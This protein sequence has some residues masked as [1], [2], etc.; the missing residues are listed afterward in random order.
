MTDPL[1]SGTAR[2][3]VARMTAA[4]A[5]HA[6]RLERRYR[7]VL[8]AQGF[9]AARMRAFLAITPAAASRL[10]ALSQFV[11]QVEYNGRRLA[12]L[13][14]DPFAAKEALKTFGALLE[15]ALPGQ[16]EPAREQ[17]YLATVLALNEAYFQVREAEAQAFFGLDRAEIEAKDLDDL[18]ERFVRILTRTFRARAGRLLV[19]DRAPAGLLARPLYIKSGQKREKLIAD[20]AMRGR[21]ASYWSFPIGEAALLQFGFDSHYPWLPRELTLLNAAAE[22]CRKAIEKVRLEAEIRRL[23]AEARRAEDEERRRIG[24]E[25]HDEAGQSLLALRLQLELMERDAGA[26]MKRRLATAREIAESTVEELRRIVAALSPSVLER[27]GLE[28][29]VRQLAVRFGK[30][31]S[32]AIRVR[33]AG[34]CA[35]LSRQRQEV[36]YRV[37]QESLQNI[38]K[39]SQAT[40]VNLLLQFTDIYIRLSVSDNGAGFAKEAA[41]SKPMSFGLAGMRE[42]AA[43]LGGGLSI[44]TAPRRGVKVVLTLPQDSAGGTHHGYN[45][46]I[47]D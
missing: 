45:S 39:H 46:H 18:L 5:P 31:H 8:R 36:I 33:F 42:R 1:L 13:N 17:L 20:P 35:G 47:T 16:F 6:D 40:R 3:F 12:R 37:A 10:P 25:L 9:D 24:R 14:V 34:D 32:A 27:L 23:D 43:L 26:V 15:A 28:A 44:H 11:E 7:K 41:L 21:H 38:A 2:R 19:S 4:I 30:M 29:A 22:R